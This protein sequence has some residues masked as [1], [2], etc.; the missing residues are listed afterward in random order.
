MIPSC[1][2]GVTSTAPLSFIAQLHFS[3]S[4]ETLSVVI[5]FRGLELQPL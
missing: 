4:L 5:W 1:T 2:M 3:C